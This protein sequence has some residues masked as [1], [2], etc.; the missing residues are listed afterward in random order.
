MPGRTN[1]CAI[2][3]TST[4]GD[5]ARWNAAL[6]GA[7]LMSRASLEKMFTPSV[8]GDYGFGW[9]VTRK[10]H[11]RE[12]H[13]GSD[14]GFAAF[15][16]RYPDQGVLIVVLSNLEDAPVRRIE[17]DLAAKFVTP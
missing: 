10:P 1:P 14:P 9:F 2:G 3:T 8:P 11:L 13:E 16:A 15:E 17:A 7:K 4:A 5:I 12:F 6:D